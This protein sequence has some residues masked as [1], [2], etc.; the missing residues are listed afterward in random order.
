MFVLPSSKNEPIY[1][2]KATED[3]YGLPLTNEQQKELYELIMKEY[4]K[5]KEG[6]IEQQKKDKIKAESKTKFLETKIE[7]QQKIKNVHKKQVFKLRCENLEK[8]L[9][10]C[11]VFL[12]NDNINTNI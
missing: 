9:K 10:K 4:E 11:G 1:E 3:F 2:N 6:L 8:K 7:L 5:D 12:Y